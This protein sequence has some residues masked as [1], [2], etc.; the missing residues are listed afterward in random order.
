MP[1][2]KS[3]AKK[4]KKP[5]IHLFI[6]REDSPEDPNDRECD[7]RLISFNTR[8]LHFQHHETL[9]KRDGTGATAAMRRKLAAGLA[10]VLSYYEHG[11]CLWYIPGTH[12]PPDMQWDGCRVAGVLIWGTKNP[13]RDMGAK[14]YEDRKKDAEAFVEHYTAWAN[15]HLYYY[16]IEDADGEMLESSGDWSDFGEM[17]QEIRPSL[18]GHRVRISGD[19]TDMLNYHPLRLP[20]PKPEEPTDDP[21]VHG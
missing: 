2:E 15:G 4:K 8:H 20:K 6:E 10:F 3:K 7:W 14:T 18:K 19:A 12:S 11:D 13:R 1:Q 9:I 21:A 17:V 5:L 16:R